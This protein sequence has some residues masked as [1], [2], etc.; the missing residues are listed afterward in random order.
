MT[1]KTALDYQRQQEILFDIAMD[2][3]SSWQKIDTTTRS[4]MMDQLNGSRGLFDLVMQWV[5]EFDRNWETC[6]D[7]PNKDYLESVGIFATDKLMALV[8]TAQDHLEF[9]AIAKTKNSYIVR[10]DEHIRK[11]TALQGA[12]GKV[13]EHE[14]QWLLTTRTRIVFSPDLN[15]INH[16]CHCGGFLVGKMIHDLHVAGVTYMSLSSTLGLSSGRT[17][18]LGKRYE[19][20]ARRKAQRAEQGLETN[21]PWADPF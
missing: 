13:T 4:V 1:K 5:E 10:F 18:N 16:L 14:H 8:A 15:E 7:D 3:G 2:V 21:M 6:P 20:E 9:K 12:G 11:I 17:S 19:N